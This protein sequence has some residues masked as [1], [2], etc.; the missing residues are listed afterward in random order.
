MAC[1]E[2]RSQAVCMAAYPF[3]PIF[4]K[5]FEFIISPAA[6]SAGLTP[7]R[8]KLELEAG[9]ITEDVLRK[10]LAARVV[11]ADVTGAN[12]NVFYEVGVAHALAKPVVLIRDV[13]REDGPLSPHSTERP[14]DLAEYFAIEYD[15][16]EWAWREELAAALE[17]SIVAA[18][19]S[20]A[21]SIPIPFR[22][23]APRSEQQPAL[24]SE[25]LSELELKLA[26]HIREGTAR[27]V[28][29]LAFTDSEEIGATRFAL[30]SDSIRPRLAQIRARDARAVEHEL[31]KLAR[32]FSN[33]EVPSGA[34]DRQPDERAQ[35]QESVS[36]LSNRGLTKSEREDAVLAIVH[37]LQH[38]GRLSAARATRI[39]TTVDELLWG[40]TETSPRRGELT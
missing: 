31:Q 11:V 18:M 36:Q 8:S 22:G 13:T 3:R 21:S 34:Q 4:H 12:A 19:K 16:N 15:R 24:L 10:L 30:S 25:R 2:E 26:R 38:A 7:T 20:P 32:Y 1:M 33:S 39:A 14:F 5:I 17:A 35:I 40:Q 29:P 9:P 37:S 23:S 27:G 28:D 6:R